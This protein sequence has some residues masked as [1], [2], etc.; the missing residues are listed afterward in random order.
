MANY[1]SFDLFSSSSREESDVFLPHVVNTSIAGEIIIKNLNST[2]K[3]TET[4]K[5]KC[6]LF[7]R[8]LKSIT[9]SKPSTATHS[10]FKKISI[11]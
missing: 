7:A 9:K 5:V 1:N 3:D 4:S 11:S 8:K 2:A 6:V 10:D